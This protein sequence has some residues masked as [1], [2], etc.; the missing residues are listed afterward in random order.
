MPKNEQTLRPIEPAVGV[1]PPPYHRIDEVRE[2]L[3][4]LVIPGGSQAPPANG[5]PNRR[6][7]LRADGR[8]EAHET[9]PLA[10]L[11]QA[12]L[13]GVSQE[14][15]RHVRLS[16]GPAISF[17]VNNPSLHRMKLQTALLKAATDSLQHLTGF[18]LCPAMDDRIVRISL[19]SDAREGPLHP[20]IERIVQKEIGQ[21]RTDHAPLRRAARPLFQGAIR[22]LHRRTYPAPDVQPDPWNVGGVFH[23]A[24]HQLMIQ[25]VEG[26]YDTR[27]AIS[28]SQS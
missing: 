9:L 25:T 18:L 26:P 10:I 2:V 22:P 13:K 21:Q 1:R 6:S 5:A 8:E 20:D 4:A 27:P 19:E 3:Q 14:V 7:G 12:R 28:T 23:G 16:P 15:E 24:F 17:A 11:G